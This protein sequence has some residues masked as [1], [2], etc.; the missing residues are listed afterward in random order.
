M[1]QEETA[2]TGSEAPAETVS[3]GKDRPWLPLLGKN[4]MSVSLY[5]VILFYNDLVKSE[6]GIIALTSDGREHR[7]E[8]LRIARI[9]FIF[10]HS[11]RDAEKTILRDYNENILCCESCEI[12][13][14]VVLANLPEDFMALK[15]PNHY[16]DTGTKLLMSPNDESPELVIS[17][18]NDILTAG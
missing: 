14:E 11:K 18:Y 6:S 16:L 9:F 5:L 10:H 8:D 15:S 2:A 12:E 4:E 13:N 7:E 1:E 3:M 17:F